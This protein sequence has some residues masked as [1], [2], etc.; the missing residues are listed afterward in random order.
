VTAS[1]DARRAARRTRRTV[2]LAPEWAKGHHRLA[3]A[4]LAAG[5]RAGAL[6]AFEGTHD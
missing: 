1:L 4:L 6:E 5:D 3:E 2:R